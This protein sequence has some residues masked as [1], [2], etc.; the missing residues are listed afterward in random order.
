MKMKAFL[1]DISP[2]VAFNALA[3]IKNRAKWDSRLASYKVVETGNNSMLVY[4]KLMTVRIP[5]LAQRDQLL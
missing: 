4:N 3:N 5:G 2:E 1:P